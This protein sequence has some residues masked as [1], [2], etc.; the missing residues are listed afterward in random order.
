MI[1]FFSS[2]LGTDRVRTRP[3]AVRKSFAAIA[4]SDSAV[5]RQ[6]RWT[7]CCTHDVDNFP[8]V[9]SASLSFT[10]SLSF[11]DIPSRNEV[12]L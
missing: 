6:E 8:S 7:I 12:A 5:S 2:L 1:V 11:L 3:R 10:E 9:D 4:M